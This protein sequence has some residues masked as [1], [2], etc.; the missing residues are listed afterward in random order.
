MSKKTYGLKGLTRRELLILR[1]ALDQ[2]VNLETKLLRRK[3]VKALG[4]DWSLQIK[5][6]DDEGEPVRVRYDTYSYDVDYAL[7]TYNPNIAK[8]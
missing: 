2:S 1:E 5:Q 3:I 7:R 4:D 8:P 6:V